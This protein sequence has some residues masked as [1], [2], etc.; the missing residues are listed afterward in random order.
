MSMPIAYS[1]E[2]IVFAQAGTDADGAGPQS[3]QQHEGQ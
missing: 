2:V 3:Q 1:R